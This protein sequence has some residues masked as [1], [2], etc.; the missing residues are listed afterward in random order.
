MRI[1]IAEDDANL[2]RVLEA[3]LKSWGHEVV[4]THNGNDALRD[5][6]QENAPLLAILDWMM[7]ELDG[8]EVCRRLRT[9]K[10]GPP[11]LQSYNNE[12]YHNFQLALSIGTVEIDHKSGLDIQE[13]M[14]RADEAMYRHKGHKKAQ[15]T[16][17]SS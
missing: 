5:L 12:R 4:V 15:K 13:Q 11:V 8:V 2:C 9:E 6:Q 10:I 14:A 17:S 1:L 16:L 7:P 3:N